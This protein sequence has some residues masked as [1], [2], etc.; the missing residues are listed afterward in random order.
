MRKRSL[1]TIAMLTGCCIL[2]GCSNQGTQTD[3]AQ[4]SQEESVADTEENTDQNT[5]PEKLDGEA[6]GWRKTGWRTTRWSGTG[7][8]R[9]RWRKAGRRGTGRKRRTGR[10]ESGT[11]RIRCTKYIYGRCRGNGRKHQFHRDG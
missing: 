1:W 8:K 7:R 2:A 4:Q 5:P 10:T 11:D 3:T 6:T 9:P